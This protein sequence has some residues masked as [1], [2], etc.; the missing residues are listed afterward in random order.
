MFG[1][2]VTASGKT[3]KVYRWVPAIDLFESSLPRLDECFAEV[4]ALG[5]EMFSEGRSVC[6]VAADDD[7]ARAAL[8]RLGTRGLFPES[9]SGLIGVLSPT[10]L[11][12]PER[13]EGIFQYQD[14]G[15]A[16]LWLTRP[17][18]GSQRLRC[19]QQVAASD[20]PLRAGILIPAIAGRAKRS[21]LRQLAVSPNSRA[22][23]ELDREPESQNDFLPS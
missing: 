3:V 18:Q 16:N 13:L 7:I 1:A 10:M 20:R 14:T 11:Q 23:P 22:E 17:V 6:L 19:T 2:R 8:D 21:S 15:F 4:K 9:W 5:V 12:E